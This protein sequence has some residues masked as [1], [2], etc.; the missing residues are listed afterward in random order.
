MD[1]NE[2]PNAR[3]A[4][5]EEAFDDAEDAPQEGD[6]VSFEHGDPELAR[7]I[8]DLERKRAEL[9]RENA[10]LERSDAA[11]KR[12][13]AATQREIATMQREAARLRGEAARFRR[14]TAEAEQQ[15][16]AL[17]HE[18][19]LVE[20]EQRMGVDRATLLHWLSLPRTEPGSLAEVEKP[21]HVEMVVVRERR[22]RRLLMTTPLFFGMAMLGQWAYARLSGGPEIFRFGAIGLLIL[23]ARA[24]F[25]YAMDSGG[26]VR[27]HLS[28]DADHVLRDGV[29]LVPRRHIRAAVFLSGGVPRVQ[30]L[31]RHGL[32]P[33]DLL[34]ADEAHGERV[35]RM[36]GFDAAR[37]GMEFRTGSQFLGG[38]ALARALSLWKVF[39]G[40]VAIAAYNGYVWPIWILLAGALAFLIPSITPGRMRVGTDGVEL[41]WLWTRR[42]IPHR[43]IVHANVEGDDLVLKPAKGKIL[44]FPALRSHAL[45]TK[46]DPSG[47]RNR[48]H[49]AQKA[50]EA[51]PGSEATLPDREGRTV[52]AWI[53]SLRQLRQ[54]TRTHYREPPLSL[55][56]L[57]RLV[58]DPAAAPVDRAGAA[59]A[60]RDHLGE[61]GRAR[62]SRIAA[63]SAEPRLRFA[64][65]VARAASPDDEVVAAIEA[66]QSEEATDTP[67]RAQ[68]PEPRR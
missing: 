31:L 19:E 49:T 5:E 48:I 16:A 39:A 32:P 1:G 7:V 36:L 62:L 67:R 9:E 42:F 28:V 40:L 4:A 30:L 63:A 38:T 58:E 8:A 50:R 55:D 37:V 22:L 65:D 56:A 25:W 68:A 6:S 53:E 2:N 21:G 12:E 57:W 10:E 66:L 29:P 44:R 60:L 33:I 14:E 35:L 23:L 41:R 34:V 59:I 43:D 11:M 18:R 47:M 26:G 27:G 64:L 17:E 61:D 24:L 51:S 46:E 20:A 15:T 52:R 13:I 54:S 3:A 45:F